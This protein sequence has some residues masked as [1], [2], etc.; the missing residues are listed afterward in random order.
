MDEGKCKKAVEDLGS[1][2]RGDLTNSNYPSGCFAF[3]NNYGYF[4]KHESGTGH[5]YAKSICKPGVYQFIDNQ[6]LS[7]IYYF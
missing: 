7:I 1:S 2:Y 4:N 3:G 6:S 5:A